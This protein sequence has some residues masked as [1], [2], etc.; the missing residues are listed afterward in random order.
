MAV[1]TAVVELVVAEAWL[2]VEKTEDLLEETIEETDVTEAVATDETSRPRQL[3]S[4]L[5][6]TP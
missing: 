2:A 3:A 4:S 5:S 6:S 1:E